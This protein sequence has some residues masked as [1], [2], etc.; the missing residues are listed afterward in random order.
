[1][2]TGN[3]YWESD[4]KLLGNGRLVTLSLFKKSTIAKA[5]V[6]VYQLNFILPFQSPALLFQNNTDQTPT[7]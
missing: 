2:E 3:I 1:M 7:N 5:A 6:I 4:Y